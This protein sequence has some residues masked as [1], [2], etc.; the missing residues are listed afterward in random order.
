MK[1]WIFFPAHNISLYPYV[2]TTNQNYKSMRLPLL[3]LLF[4]TLA[5]VSCM[6]DTYLS[7]DKGPAP[8][9]TWGNI[10]Y[11][12]NGMVLEKTQQLQENTYGYRFLS[13]GKLIHR[14]NSGFCGTPPITTSDYEGSWE[15]DGDIIRLEAAFWGG[16]QIQEWKINSHAGN[17][18]QIE[19]LSSQLE[20]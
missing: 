16:R 3:A 2:Q 5:F 15:R 12:D 10:R 7:A 13:N 14:A 4:V 8:I 9:G 6:D 20:M 11:Q 1:F 17:T 19:V 18:F